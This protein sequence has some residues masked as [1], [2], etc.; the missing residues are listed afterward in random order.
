MPCPF[1]DRR[2]DARGADA[3]LPGPFGLAGA[4]RG[5]GARPAFVSGPNGKKIADMRSWPERLGDPAAQRF[6]EVNE[7]EGVKWFSK[8]SFELLAACISEIAF[9]EGW[10][11]R[12]APAALAAAEASGYRWKDFLELLRPQDVDPGL[13]DAE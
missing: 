12:E 2:M 11:I 3:R 7:F 9:L 5:S 10:E 8:E 1:L 4:G 13:K 6:L